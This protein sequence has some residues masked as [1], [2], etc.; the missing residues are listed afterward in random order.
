M[1][2]RTL[3]QQHEAMIERQTV[4]NTDAMG[5]QKSYT[6]NARGVLPRRTKCRIVELSSRERTTYAARGI[7]ASHNVYVE[8]TDPQ[9][10]ERDR[11]YEVSCGGTTPLADRSY[12][13]VVGVRN[14]DRLN[15][16]WIVA[17][18]ETKDNKP[19]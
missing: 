2:L 9:V 15:R 1:S 17:C 18:F 5:N 12:M 11:L 19:K 7:D 10:D 3:C 6:A 4:V 16:F 14:P 13:H 8:G